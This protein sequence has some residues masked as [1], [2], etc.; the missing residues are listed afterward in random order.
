MNVNFTFDPLGNYEKPI[1]TLCN[2]QR[3]QIGIIGETENFVLTSIF[4]GLSELSFSINNTNPYYKKLRKNRLIKLENIGWFIID[5]ES[6]VDDGASC[7]KEVRCSSYEVILNRQPIN[8]ASGTYQFWNPVSPADTLLGKII[9]TIP[10][11]KI[12]YVSSNL[13]AVFRT[14]EIDDTPLYSFLMTDL[15]DAYEC[16]VI[17][18]TDTKT[19]NFYSPVDVITKTN[20]MLSTNNLVNDINIQTV[21]DDIITA[22]SV[23]G[24]STLDISLVNPM[25]T[26]IIYNFDYFKTTEWM[27]QELITALTTWQNK[28]N[29]Q[30]TV[31]ANLLSNLKTYNS[32]LIILNGELTELINAYH[33]LEIVRT[34]RIVQGASNLSDITN[35][36]N[37]NANQQNN[38]NTQIASKQ[39][40]INTTLSSLTNIN[41]SLQFANNFSNTL[42]EELENF[43]ITGTFQNENF[44][45]LESMSSI[46]EQDMA[47][48]LYSQGISKLIE[49]S[50]PN[51]SFDASV[52]NYPFLK[53]FETFTRQTQLGC[54]I[55]L[56]VEE[57]VWVEPVLLKMVIPYDNPNSFEMVFSNKLRLNEATW[58]FAEL[59]N[60]ETKASNKV[61]I[62]G[63]TWNESARKTDEVSSYI[64]N[65]LD[66]TKQNIHSTSNLETLIDQHGIWNRLVQSNGSFDPQQMRITN[67][68][69]AFT[70]DN[71]QTVS[72]AVGRIPDPFGNG[73]AYGVVGDVVIGTL[74]AG[75]QLLITNQDS[76]FTVD[77]QKAS[78]YNCILEVLRSNNLAR[79]YIN[80]DEG[81]KIQTRTSTSAAWRDS[82]YANYDGSIIANDIVVTR[83]KIGGFN[84]TDNRIY[85]NLS[86]SS[87]AVIDLNTNGTGRISGFSW[88]PT[89]SFFEG[90]INAWWGHIG[91]F[92]IND[93]SIRS[94]NG[95]LLLNYDGSVYMTAGY[96][97]G[98]EINPRS[99]STSGSGY[100]GFTFRGDGTGEIGGFLRWDGTTAIF[101]GEIQWNNGAGG[102]E[103]DDV[104]NCHI[105]AENEIHITPL[106]SWSINSEWLIA[107]YLVIDNF[108]YRGD[109]YRPRQITV[110]N[111][112]ITVLAAD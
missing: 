39:S 7:Y 108:T 55:N 54:S 40:Q 110:G 112:T 34:E 17:F 13:W 99:I 105:F 103:Y 64:E 90:G 12:G 22:M 47:Q 91:R 86:D 78:L 25:G 51:Y 88:T 92:I 60:S 23:I 109:R 77:G 35:Q 8:I 37:Q 57:G 49:L 16:I 44:G 61:S 32:E 2:P 72:Q 68:V 6:I 76:S 62:S 52:M 59:R 69:I 5:S 96:I 67:N 66:L 65:A 93:N 29:S 4:N 31:Y 38:K 10:T 36:I 106:V 100:S 98:I 45:V 74:L 24:D 56:E 89:E 30:Q 102:I 1:A 97:G 71:W 79:T 87:G 46:E 53:E 26:N 14:F 19:I 94:D 95:R 101:A 70:K 73:Y 15:S 83:A 21:S 107:T 48:Q 104:G 28:F 3:N 9:S 84:I 11:W 111:E 18:D 33:I 63:L 75:N 80:P 43:I 82:F 41:T 81:I 20:I 50:Q 27:T 42:L 58:T 85:S